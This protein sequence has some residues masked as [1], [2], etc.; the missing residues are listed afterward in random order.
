MIELGNYLV[1]IENEIR[2]I[3]HL[4]GIQFEHCIRFADRHRHRKLMPK[5]LYQRRNSREL[6]QKMETAVNR[7][8]Y[9]YISA[10]SDSAYH[11]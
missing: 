10:L 3:C 11:K 6:Y 7:G 8:V 5:P 1:Y 4:L 9:S 2:M